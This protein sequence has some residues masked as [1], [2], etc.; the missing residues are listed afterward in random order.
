MKPYRMKRNI[1]S[2]FPFQDEGSTPVPSQQGQTEHPLVRTTRPENRAGQFLAEAQGMH[3][4]WKPAFPP[5]L[6]RISNKWQPNNTH[7]FFGL[8][9]NGTYTTLGPFERVRKSSGRCLAD[10]LCSLCFPPLPNCSSVVCLP[11]RATYM[12]ACGSW[13]AMYRGKPRN[14]ACDN[15]WNVIDRWSESK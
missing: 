6:T 3:M 12:P 13:V 2:C 10:R 11:P 14:L 1:L 15:A 4:R 5:H 7:C 8:V 9:G